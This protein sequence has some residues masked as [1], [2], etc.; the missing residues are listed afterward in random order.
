MDSFS[1]ALLGKTLLALAGCAFLF[2]AS[3]VTVTAQVTIDFWHAMEGPKGPVLKEMVND[4]MK[5]NPK[6]KVNV[7]LQGGYTDM[8]RKVQAGIAANALP[9]LAMLGQRHGIPQIS[10]SDRLLT[11]DSILTAEDRKDINPQLFGR[12]TYQG[13]LMAMPF[14]VSVP[15]LHINATRFK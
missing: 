8:V 15:V 12:Y 7:S 5:Q 1:H 14:A 11:L 6:I 3:V 10:D 2:F 13:R 4:F 9:D